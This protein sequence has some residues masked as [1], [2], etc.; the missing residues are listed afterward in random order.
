MPLIIDAK[1]YQGGCGTRWKETNGTGKSL[2]TIF[3]SHWSR[4]DWPQSLP[5]LMTEE[6]YT[7][8]NFKRLWLLTNKNI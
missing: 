6:C 7:F 8:I 5:V 1:G 3:P 4:H 2:M